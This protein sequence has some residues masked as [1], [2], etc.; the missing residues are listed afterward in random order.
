MDHTDSCDRFPRA[1]DPTGDAQREA[2]KLGWPKAMMS[3]SYGA[4]VVQAGTQEKFARAMQ[5]FI[6]LERPAST[7]S[8]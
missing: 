1:L 8:D 5:D 2:A 6:G 3:I 7:T 4:T